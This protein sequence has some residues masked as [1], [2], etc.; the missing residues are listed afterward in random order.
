MIRRH[1]QQSYR[2]LATGSFRRPFDQPAPPTLT[3][4][5]R[6]ILQ[7]LAVAGLAM[8]GLTA[9]G[10]GPTEIFDAIVRWL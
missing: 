6:W 3:R 8:Q 9:V 4:G 1:R 7:G 10:I 5:Q 2:E